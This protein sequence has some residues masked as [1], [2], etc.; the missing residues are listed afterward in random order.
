MTRNFHL[1]LRRDLNVEAMRQAAA[2]FV[3]E[4]EYKGLQVKSGKPE[5]ATVRLVT[6]AEVRR[7]GD[8]VL[9]D[10]W[11]K[12]FMYKQ[13]RSMAGLLLAVGEGRVKPEETEGLMSGEAGVRKTEVAPPQGLTLVKV[14]YDQKEFDARS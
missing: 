2:F 11:G 3:G 12:G 1:L 9:I 10:I 5:E 13:V 14:Y 4:K 6:A 8:L 7:E